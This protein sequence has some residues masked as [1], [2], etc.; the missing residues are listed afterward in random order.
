MQQRWQQQ[1]ELVV[2]K[3]TGRGD[4]KDNYRASTGEALSAAQQC[5]WGAV[6]LDGAPPSP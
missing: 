3:T 4:H 2:S 6:S 1:G 5:L